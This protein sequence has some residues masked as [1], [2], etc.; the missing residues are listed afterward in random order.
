MAL[1]VAILPD[2]QL[3]A[4]NEIYRK[5]V[6][7]K[8][9]RVTIGAAIFFA[10]LVIA[11]IGAEVN[12]GRWQPGLDQY[13]RLALGLEKMVAAVRRNHPDQ[14]CRNPVRRRTRLCA[15]FSRG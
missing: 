6:A 4:L 11:P 5:A 8:R 15:E 3:A 14:L 1:A 7:R 2:Q 12:A 9:L 10:A 13:S